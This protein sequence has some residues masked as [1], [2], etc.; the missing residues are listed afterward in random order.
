MPADGEQSP[1][2]EPG[3]D[4]GTT[5]EAEE[6]AGGAEENELERVHRAGRVGRADFVGSA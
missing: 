1:V 5:D 6:V 2:H 3:D 4:R